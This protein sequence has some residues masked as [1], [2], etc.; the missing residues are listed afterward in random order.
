MKKLLIMG[1]LVALPACGN[2]TV[3]E[4]PVTGRVTSVPASLVEPCDIDSSLDLEKREAVLI[5]L[6]NLRRA[7]INR[8]EAFAI[9][10][11][12]GLSASEIICLDAMLDVVY[13]PF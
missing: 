2:L 13:G 4:H 9:F 7:G 1:L 3:L 6:R 5:T 8:G 10:I 11:V 12:E